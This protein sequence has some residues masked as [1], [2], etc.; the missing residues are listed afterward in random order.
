MV[1]KIQPQFFPQVF[2][3]EGEQPLDQSGVSNKFTQLA[4]QIAV[5]TNTQNSPEHV[6]EGFLKIA[7][8]NMANAIKKISVQRGYD[9]GDYTLCC[10]GA[11][12]GQHACRLAETLGMKTIVIHPYAGVLS[13]Y[14]MGL[15]DRRVLKE[16]SVE[17][18]LTPEVVP[19]IAQQLNALA[20]KAMT[21][22]KEQGDQDIETVQIVQQVHVRYEGTDSSLAVDF[23]EWDVMR[24]QFQ[25]RYQQQYGITLPGKA[26][27]AS[28]LTAEVIG[29]TEHLRRIRIR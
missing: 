29:K 20:D 18:T 6:A 7:I 3:P 26:L 8:A 4:Q 11:A 16:A 12:G 2:G 17:V 10:F 9:V 25:K 15:A 13:A 23:A 28:T 19:A 14:G 1:G 27:V 5:A 22:L 24:S 21:E